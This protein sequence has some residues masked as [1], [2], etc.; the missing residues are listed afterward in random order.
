MVTPES[1]H[2]S[3]EA[4]LACEHVEVARRRPA[5]RGGHRLG[6]VRGTVAGPAAPARLRRARRA[7]ARGDPRAVDA[8]AHARGMGWRAPEWM[9]APHR[10]RARRCTA[11]CRCPAPR[12]RRCRSCARRCSRPSRSRSPTCRALNDVRHDA[13]AAR[14]DGRG[15][16]R[17]RRRAL[18]RSMPR[19]IDWPLAPYELVKTMRASI[20]ALGP[21]LARCGE[22][23]VSLP[24]GCAIGLRP[25]D[26]HVKG[27]RGDGRRRSTSSTATST[28]ER[29][30][31]AGHALRV[32]HGDGDRHREPDDGGDA[33]RRARRRSRTP[34]ASRRSS[35]SR[36]ASSRWARAS[37]AR[38]PTASS[39]RASRG[40]MARPT[41]SCPTASRPAR[42]SPPSRP[43]AAMRRTRRA[44]P[45]TLDAVLDKLR[46]AGA[47]IDVDGDAI[48]VRAHGPA[49][50][51]Q[52]SHR[53]AIRAFRPTCRRS[54]WRWR[55]ARGHV[56]GHRDD[57]REPD[58]ARAGA[59]APRRA[60]SR[61]RATPRSSR[62]SPSSPAPT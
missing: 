37:P 39:S 33:R 57:L 59:G 30:G 40:C 5:L 32:R 34:R 35:T 52:R 18:S 14:A 49:A 21:L 47:T 43:P 36:A 13:D 6:V 4:G 54:S 20:L 41:R 38:A 45:S 9:T 55:R 19:T 7:H 58:D 31:C 56:G 25:V 12:T 28:R 48:R 50:R 26:Q 44:A 8:D 23:R 46:E 22:A 1:I 61:S 27:L 51:R 10:G 24:G 42:S 16:R 17:R 11:K 62:A 60:T 29:R 15:A 2:A 3:I 53:A